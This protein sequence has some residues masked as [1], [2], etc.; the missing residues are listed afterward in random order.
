MSESIT[1][2]TTLE[3]TEVTNDMDC[4]EQDWEKAIG[5]AFYSADDV[6]VVKQ[7]DFIIDSE[8]KEEVKPCPIC[9]KSDKLYITSRE[10]F[11]TLAKEKDCNVAVIRCNGCG[12]EVYSHYT[13]KA[14]GYEPHIN[15]AIQKWNSLG[16]KR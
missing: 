16:G 7:Q 13:C 11:E 3:I 1:R 2:V 12:L 5:M 8:E 15:E 9:G 10:N 6:T 14:H 4:L